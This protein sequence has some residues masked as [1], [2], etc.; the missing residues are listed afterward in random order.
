[1]NAIEKYEIEELQE[2]SVEEKTAFEIDNLDSLNWAFR[3]INALNVQKKEFETLAATEKKR[4]AEW[5]EKE[6]SS[7]KDSIRYF[8]D[9]IR[10]YHFNELQ[11][12]PKKKSIT[13]PYGKSKST[14]SKEQPEKVDED[15][16]LEHLKANEL[17]QFIQ[18]KESLKWADLKKV[19][20]IVELENGTKQCVDEN[21]QIVPGIAVKEQNT[22]FKVEV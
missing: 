12:D 1:M 11:I 15:A 7:I 22:T 13:T 8:E 3:K 2:G 9:A 5:E 6:T 18:V 10:L 4:I 21:G 20:T 16:A 17:N 14:T 19:V